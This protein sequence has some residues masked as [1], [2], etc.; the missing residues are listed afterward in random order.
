[1][2]SL[3]SQGLLVWGFI[4]NPRALYHEALCPNLS[5]LFFA[6]SLAKLPRLASNLWSSCVSLPNHWYHRYVPQCLVAR[7]FCRY[8][9][10]FSCFIL[11]FILVL[12]LFYPGLAIK[13]AIFLQRSMVLS[14]KKMVLETNTWLL[15]VLIPDRVPLIL[16]PLSR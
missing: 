1:M 4:L 2:S 3:R 13:L 11:I 16:S 12:V 10:K 7:I 15:G 5:C 14:S 8:T 9:E 6:F